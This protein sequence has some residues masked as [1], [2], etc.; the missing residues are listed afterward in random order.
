MFAIKST[1]SFVSVFV[2]EFKRWMYQYNNKNINTFFYTLQY[3]QPNPNSI[4][5][6]ENINSQT[7]PQTKFVITISIFQLLVA[8]LFCIFVRYDP[9]IDPKFTEFH[10]STEYDPYPC[11]SHISVPIN[12]YLA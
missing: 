5:I 9:S 4:M 8:I 12:H 10:S 6:I 7:W 1:Y 11:K 3:N 2:F